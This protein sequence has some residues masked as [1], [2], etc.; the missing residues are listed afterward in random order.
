M[1]RDLRHSLGR[2]ATTNSLADCG[3]VQQPLNV[4][5][6]CQCAEGRP[7]EACDDQHL[8]AEQMPV[9]L[10]STGFVV[11]TAPRWLNMPRT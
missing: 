9:A 11:V 8:Y 10:A 5:V 3:S 7:H 1:G 2:P 4:R 6:A